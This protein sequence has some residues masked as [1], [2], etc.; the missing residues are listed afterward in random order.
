MKDNNILR[1]KSKQF[2]VDI[3]YLAKELYEK[4]QFIF[5]N[6]ILRSGTSIGANIAESIYAASRADFVNKLQI[7]Q[8]EASETKYWLELLNTT[9]I[10]DE[11]LFNRLME[12]VEELLKLLGTII[13]S[14]KSEKS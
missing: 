14:C 11:V 13:L 9:E 10:I 12:Q 8:K 3:V 2:A 1:E 5:A 4:K 7:A 6:Q